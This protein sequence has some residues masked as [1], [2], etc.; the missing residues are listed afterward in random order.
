MFEEKDFFMRMIKEFTSAIGKIK[1]LK[2]ENKIEESQEALS[3]TIEY[4]MGLNK[5]V[6]EVL[7]YDILIHKLSGGRQINTEK[8]FMLAELLTLQADIYEA[9]GKKTKARNLELKSLDILIN[10]LLNDDE[11]VSDQNQGKI[12]KLIERIGWF[13]VS[14]ESKLLLFRYYELTKNYAKAEDVL[15]NLIESDGASDDILGKG[16]AFYERL[17][18]EDHAELEKGNLPIDEVLEGL[19]NLKEYKKS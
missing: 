11:S 4:F 12:N 18:N 1:G 5:E 15:F 19:A 8:Y 14:D 7:P 9:N 13:N 17:T 10:V 6:I 2:A 3:E 16:I